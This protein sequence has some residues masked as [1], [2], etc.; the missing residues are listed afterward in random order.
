MLQ[1]KLEWQKQSAQLANLLN[2]ENNISLVS[3]DTSLV[4]L[5]LSVQAADTSGFEKRPEYLG[6]NAELKSFQTSKKSINQG[7]LLPKLRVGF[8]NGEFGA[9]SASLYNTYQLN[10]ALIWTIPLGRIFYKG[11]LKQWNS[12]IALQQN[13]V[14]QFKNEYQQETTS[15]DARLQIA[16]EQMKFA[17]DALQLT[18]EAMNQSIERQKLVTV[19]PFEVFQAQQFYL[20]SKVDYLKSVSE[21]NKAQFALKV[22]EGESL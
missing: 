7:L 12:K 9:Y 17:K 2:L 20:K 3:T 19:K 14:E 1:A 21:Y 22:A 16:N 18:A 10:A 8:D 13:K 6:L 5:S 11:D 4:P 15:A